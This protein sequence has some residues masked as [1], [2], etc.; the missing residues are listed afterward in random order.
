MPSK[1]DRHQHTLRV[2]LSHHAVYAAAADEVGVDYNT[3]LIRRL[4]EAHGLPEKA[5]PVAE[6]LALLEEARMT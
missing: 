5:E 1:G 4:A 6:Q 2:P 3:Y